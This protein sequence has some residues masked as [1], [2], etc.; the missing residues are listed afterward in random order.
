MIE[1][2]YNDTDQLPNHKQIENF[3][4]NVFNYLVS[5]E[6]IEL[7]LLLSNN[8]FLQQLN[9]QYRKK[10]EPTDVLSFNSKQADIEWVNTNIEDYND[11]VKYLG[12][13]AISLEKVRENAE[14]F[15]VSFDEE[16]KRLIIHGFLHLLGY[17]HQTND[18]NEP[19]LIKQEIILNKL[20]S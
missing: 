11:N 19:M 12:D 5:D 3:V 2:Y 16:L 9:L 17:D 8:N 6:Q 1:I 18:N 14:Y 15:N 20:N 7:C 4:T 10:D 13:I